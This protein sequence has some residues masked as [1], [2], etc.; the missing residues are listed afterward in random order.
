VTGAIS[1]AAKATPL[2]HANVGRPMVD[3]ETGQLTRHGTQVLSAYR[4]HVVGSNRITPC[5]A[6]GTN[7]ISLTPNDSAP[8]IE[9]YVDYEF[10]P[11]V[12]ANN[13]TGAVTMT[14]VPRTGALATLKA[15]KTNGSAQA[16][17][18]DITAGLLYIAVYV[19][20][21]DSGAG[22]FVLK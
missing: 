18:G 9:K 5:S 8:V 21:L 1:A 10:F 14:V 20:S 12:A 11:F 15:Y 16:G 4:E 2:P 3:T 7:V 22:G 17:A 19:D 6:S 13:S